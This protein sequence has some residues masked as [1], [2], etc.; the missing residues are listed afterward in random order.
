M[1][2]ALIGQEDH[3]HQPIVYFL[4]AGLVGVIIF[5]AALAYP[6]ESEDV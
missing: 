4:I 3:N 5:I 2:G 6:K 1:G